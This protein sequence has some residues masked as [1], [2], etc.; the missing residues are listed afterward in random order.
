MVHLFGV[1][2]SSWYS[3]TLCL[4]LLFTPHFCFHLFQAYHGRVIWVFMLLST[5]LPAV[6]LSFQITKF[7]LFVLHVPFLLQ[8][9]FPNNFISFFFWVSIFRHNNIARTR[10]FPAIRVWLKDTVRY[11]HPYVISASAVQLIISL[12]ILHNTITTRMTVLCSIF[13]TSLEVA[14]EALRHTYSPL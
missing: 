5:V 3:A 13:M 7:W 11:H 10:T 12:W 14:V 2:L 6:F 4:L 8:N 9:F 1:P